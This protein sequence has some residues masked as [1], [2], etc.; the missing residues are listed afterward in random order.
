MSWKVK[1]KNLV[2]V[3]WKD[4]KETEKTCQQN[5]LCEFWLD[6]VSYLRR[7]MIMYFGV[8]LHEVCNSEE[9]ETANIENKNTW[10]IHV[11]GVRIFIVLFTQILCRW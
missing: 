6:P 9:R 7:H 5:V 3:L 1:K 4:K 10:W 8:K 11:Q 2:F